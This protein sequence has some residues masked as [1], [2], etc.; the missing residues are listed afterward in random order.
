[1]KMLLFQDK[2]LKFLSEI[3]M[4]LVSKSDGIIV[5]SPYMLLRQ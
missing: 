5:Y 4:I 2:V 3:L 1:M